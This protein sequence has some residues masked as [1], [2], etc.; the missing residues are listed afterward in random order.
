MSRPFPHR[1]PYTRRRPLPLRG[2]ASAVGRERN[3][4]GAIGPRSD[5]TDG[6]AEYS[7]EGFWFVDTSALALPRIYVTEVPRPPPRRR[8]G[9]LHLSP[10][11][12]C[13]PR[14]GLAQLWRYLRQHTRLGWMWVGA[15]DWLG[16]AG[17]G[18][19]S[20]AHPGA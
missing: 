5:P 18:M 14:E 19:N 7:A 17:T 8:G 9:G 11:S 6:D 16:W 12:L 1:G 3:P 4:N 20:Q 13:S 15:Q 10:P 2:P